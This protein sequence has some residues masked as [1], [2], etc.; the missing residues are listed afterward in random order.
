[1]EKVSVLIPTRQR[2]K[3]LAKCLNK[4]FENTVYPNYEVVVIADKD[5]PESIEVVRKLKFDDVKVL[6]KEKRE[7]YVGKI[8]EGYHKTDSPLMVFLADDVEVQK[9]WLTEAVKTFSDS[10]SDKMGLV[11]FQDE[12]DNR[13]AA[14]GLISR[15]YVE[16]FLNGNIFYPGYVHYWCDC[17]LTVRSKKWGRY[18]HSDRA[19]IFHNRPGK[20]EKRDKIGQEGLM[21]KDLG[22]KLFTMRQWLGFPDV[23]PKRE[24]L[25]LPDMVPLH[26]EPDDDLNFYFGFGIDTRKK[27]DWTLEKEKAEFLLSTFPL[28]WGSPLGRMWERKEKKA[29]PGKVVIHFVPSEEL[30]FYFGFGIDTRKK[31]KWEVDK[32]IAEFLL[33]NFVLNW[34]CAYSARWVDGRLV[35]RIAPEHDICLQVWNRPEWTKRVLGSIDKNTHWDLVRKFFIM[36]DNSEEETKAILE[37]YQNPKKVIVR[38]NFGSA[39]ESLLKFTK[40]A[41]TE[42]VFNLENDA[43]VPKDWNLI[44]AK[45][46]MYDPSIGIIKGISQD[47]PPYIHWNTALAGFDLDCLKDLLNRMTTDGRWMHGRWAKLLDKKWR[48]HSAPTLFFDKLDYHEEEFP[49]IDEYHRKGWSKCPADIRY[50]KQVIKLYKKRK[51]PIDMDMLIDDGKFHSDGTDMKPFIALLTG[52]VIAQDAKLILEIGTG[53]L[54]SSKAFLYGLERTGGMLISCDPLKRWDDFHHPQLD[55]RQ[56][57]SRD[58]ARGW[59][60]PVD[61]LFIDGDHEYPSVKDDF[62]S[63]YPFV[64]DGGLVVFHDSNHQLIP[65]VPKAIG[66]VPNLNRL[67]FPKF[68]GLTILQKSDEKCL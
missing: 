12:F 40:L 60:E 55:F 35:M 34:E 5:D 25:E 56:E 11:S 16:T 14:H 9:N 2:Y 39:K 61:I 10:F 59:K 21:T 64:R 20:I 42:V 45:E 66:E 29:L 36:D 26:F 41:K 32:E 54:N 3:K 19:R 30:E 17:E 18:A 43:L 49:L 57:K 51:T 1:M 37:S 7:M 24:H 33:T 67:S 6:V 27:L 68:P 44:M 28:H 52:L 31:L 15:K 48:I 47:L 63:F 38:E 13:L 22:K 8:N 23:M 65:G 46:F 58:I 53:L 4:L 50:R 62:D